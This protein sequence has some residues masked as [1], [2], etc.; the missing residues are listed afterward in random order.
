MLPT[1]QKTNPKRRRR[2][3]PIAVTGAVILLLI[4]AVML[5]L[6]NETGARFRN[7][8]TGWEEYSQAADPRGIWI[9]EIRGYFGYGGMI[10][11][12]K[13][14]VLRQDAK[15]EKT[16]R[17]QS[18]FLMDAIETYQA[19]RP[20]A[21]EQEALAR[22][23]R[24]VEEYTRNIEI[25][26]IS[27]IEGKTAEQI[28]A[29]VRVDDSGALQALAVL[30]RHWLDG[31]QR[32]L[33]TIVAALSE[34]DALVRSLAG[35]MVLLTA[36][37]GLIAM[38]IF[39]LV[40]NA[41]RSNAAQLKELEA[42]KIAQVSERKLA[43]VV[44]Q[45]PASI[46]ITDTH[47]TIEFANRKLLE[48]TGYTEDELVG[49]SP[50]ILKSGHTPEAAYKDIWKRLSQGKPWHGIFK[51]LRKDGSHYWAKT[52]LLP[53]LNEQG[54][55]TN[56]I[57]VGEDITEKRQVDEQIA[58]VQKMEA[59]GILAGSIAHDFNN[60]LMTIIGNTELIK[61]EAED[62]GAPKE[63]H[64]S[65]EHIEIASRRARALIQQLLA[66]ARQQPGQARRL[67][68]HEAIEEALE[69][70]RVST[71]PS[72]KISFKPKVKQ[73]A[74][75]IDPTA[76]FQIVMNLCHNAVEAI[77]DKGGEIELRLSRIRKGGKNGLKPLPKG[78][79]GT[80]KLEVDDN[81][82]GIPAAIQQK[83]FEPFFST[84][85]VGKGTGLGLAI[86]RNWVEESDGQVL[87]D[88]SP[89]TGSCFTILFPEYKVVDRKTEQQDR[90][91]GG[92]E[93]I[94]L[95]D[96]EEDLL[97]TIRRMMARLGYRVEAFSDPTLA[98][99]AFRANPHSYD[100]IV[101]DMMMPGM[102][103]VELITALHEIRSDLPAMMI[104]SYMLEGSLPDGFDDVVKV[105][106]PVN[107]AGLAE[108]MRLALDPKQG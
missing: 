59:V 95:V 32:N 108:A 73:V 31:R 11:N 14:Y 69:L 15:Y 34:G 12:F 91:P 16:L 33:N 41:L 35:V 56:Y 98:L 53:L 28:D 77:G 57:G 3:M 8:K 68:L 23:K 10:H 7:I 42:R 67:E 49:K 63:L 51:N 75:E 36:L 105:Q 80:I 62:L 25:I 43:W 87:L 85:P 82:P 89:Q 64:H 88:S 1:P 102:S 24:V 93:H 100:A 40:G 81:G 5:A 104:S 78:A 76:F 19:S 30:E 92:H 20:D 83:V 71:S 45:S 90:V 13:N 26:G 46:M 4:L 74:T 96:D 99:H 48:M 103:G 72:V 44:Q 60:V 37:V 58:Q 84:K 22:I 66:F 29:L 106:K 47:G 55:T 52:S 38:M 54:E 6:S 65:I 107:M 27:I 97:Y 94:L 2:M 50:S 86:V 101:T 39:T 17:I 70:I 79:I 18:R 9:S 21:I 61:L